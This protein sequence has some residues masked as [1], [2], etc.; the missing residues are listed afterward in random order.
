MLTYT[1]DRCGRTQTCRR[2]VG[3]EFEY[4]KHGFISLVVPT[5]GGIRDLCGECKPLLKGA[6][7]LFDKGRVSMQDAIDSAITKNESST[8][9]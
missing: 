8:S 1:C 9:Q 3:N 2:I 5:S 6:A 7:D 4:L